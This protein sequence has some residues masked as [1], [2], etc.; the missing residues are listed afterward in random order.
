MRPVTIYGLALQAIII[1]GY[2]LTIQV[3]ISGPVLGVPEEVKGNNSLCVGHVYPY[4][5]L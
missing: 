2:L 1:A 3:F 4:V 5:C